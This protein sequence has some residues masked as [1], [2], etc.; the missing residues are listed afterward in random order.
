M[1]TR[2]QILQAAAIA[3]A[4][5]GFPA[6]TVLDVAELTGMTKGAV[7]FHYANKEA[8]AIA[9]VEAFYRQWPP[10]ADEVQAM[11]LSPLDMISELLVRTAVRFRDDK[12]TQAGARLQIE[13][14]LINAKLQ[15][16]FVDYTAIL[17][18]LLT[19]AAEAGQLPEGSRPDTLARVLISAFFG[20]QHITWVKNDRADIVAGIHEVLEAVLP[21]RS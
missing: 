8:L 18:R 15:S 9:V 5:K 2:A 6:V 10:L 13:R 20:V 4:D 21:R 19:R 16:P 14:S 12:I 7:Y 1:R 11:D 3:F 17:E